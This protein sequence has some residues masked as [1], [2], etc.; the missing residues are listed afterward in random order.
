MR[1]VLRHAQRCCATVA[2]EG[3]TAP[4]R[5]WHKTLVLNADYT[6]LSITSAI[7]SL[8]LIDRQKAFALE[9]SP[10]HLHSEVLRLACPS[11][12]VLA[13][14]VKKTPPWAVAGADRLSVFRRDRGVC[15]YCSAPATTVDHVVPKS[16]GGDSS[17]SNLVCACLACNL[18]KGNK[19]LSQTS[20]S[21]VR[22]P[23]TPTLQEMTRWRIDDRRPFR[24]RYAYRLEH[25][26]SRRAACP[27]H[28]ARTP[29]SSRCARHLVLWVV[30]AGI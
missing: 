5:A 30:R 13:Q 14:Y 20:M 23:R 6:P 2:A 17:W 29:F 9:M 15:Q 18:R 11:V 8:G 27:A 4:G 22:Q 16:K 21:L 7:R 26:W 1:A 28:R 10:H 24:K 25:A 3:A 19:L 12:I